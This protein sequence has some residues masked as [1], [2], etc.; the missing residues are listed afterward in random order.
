MRQKLT[1]SLGALVGR[2][3]PPRGNWAFNTRACLYL[4]VLRGLGVACGFE[5]WSRGSVIC[6]IYVYTVPHGEFSLL[7]PVLC[8]CLCGFLPYAV[9]WTWWAREAGEGGERGHTGGLTD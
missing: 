3:R 4:G 8:W 1:L 9:E 5:T 7:L 6:N 2:G